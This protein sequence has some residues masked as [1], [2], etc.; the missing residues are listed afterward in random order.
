MQPEGNAF[1]KCITGF[2]RLARPKPPAAIYGCHFAKFFYKVVMFNS[3][4][5]YDLRNF[6]QWMTK[7]CGQ[8]HTGTHSQIR[9]WPD[10]PIG[11]SVDG[12]LHWASRMGL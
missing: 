2:D 5:Q 10:M 1:A 6:C 9:P 4:S 7:G 3:M 8:L 12:I 11:V